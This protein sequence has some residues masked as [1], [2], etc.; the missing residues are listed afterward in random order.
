MGRHM[1]KNQVGADGCDLIQAGLTKFTLYVVLLGKAENHHGF[2][3][4]TSA[5]FQLASEASIFAI[6]A[7]EP[8]GNSLS[9]N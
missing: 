2:A 6:L 4:T 5:A 9:N 7:S 8:Q 1:A 3:H